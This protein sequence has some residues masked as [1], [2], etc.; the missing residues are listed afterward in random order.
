MLEYPGVTDS[1]TLLNGKI[2]GTGK[3]HFGL[4]PGVIGTVLSEQDGESVPI[5]FSALHPGLYTASLT[6]LTDQDAAYGTPGDS[7]TYQLLAQVVPE[8]SSL[9]LFGVAASASCML[10]ARRRRSHTA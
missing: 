4:E 2:S 10:R 3:S 5:D 1:A 7:F 8:P 6:I 9:A